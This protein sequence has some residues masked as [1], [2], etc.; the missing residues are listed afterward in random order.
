M[1]L[2]LSDQR[3]VD[4]QRIVDD[5]LIGVTG[6]CIQHRDQRSV[7]KRAEHLGPCGHWT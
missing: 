7:W 2:T 6:A 4:S 1:S 3:A 5:C